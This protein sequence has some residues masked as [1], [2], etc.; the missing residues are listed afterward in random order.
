MKI[1]AHPKTLSGVMAI[2]LVVLIILLFRVFGSGLSG[3][4]I[5]TPASTAASISNTQP[6]STITGASATISPV[7]PQ[8]ISTARS[9]PLELLAIC[10]GSNSVVEVNAC[11][12]S[13][14]KYGNSLRAG[15][16]V[17]F[18]PSESISGSE[19]EFSLNNDSTVFFLTNI[20]AAISDLEL[21]MMHSIKIRRKGEEWSNQI[22]FSISLQ[23]PAAP[24]INYVCVDMV[25]SPPNLLL[26]PLISAP[27]SFYP[28]VES[29]SGLTDPASRH[30][31]TEIMLDNDESYLGCLNC[32]AA[33]AAGISY[34]NRKEFGVTGIFYNWDLTDLAEGTHSMRARLRNKLYVGPWSDV[35]SFNVSRP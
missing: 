23:K 32:L 1:L 16:N 21:G 17:I 30:T 20:D 34:E 14:R 10:S 7:S 19:L 33:Q 28:V 2:L 24:V 27:T 25:C 11:R 31:W 26:A 5:A 8:A 4:D 13:F 18:I 3:E 9:E 15:E 35:F 22:E 6:V 12:E 29:I